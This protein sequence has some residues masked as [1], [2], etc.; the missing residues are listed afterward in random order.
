MNKDGTIIICAVSS[1]PVKSR[2]EVAILRWKEA[3]LVKESKVC[4]NHIL[5][6]DARLV[7][8]IGALDSEDMLKVQGILKKALYV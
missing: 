3:G 8:K 1:R 2:W 7:N 5:S 4:L 6:I